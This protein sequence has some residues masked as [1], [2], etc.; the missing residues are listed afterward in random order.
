MV[1]RIFSKDEDEVMP[2]PGEGAALTD[3]EKEILQK[4]ISEG[5]EYERHWAFRSPVKSRLSDLKEGKEKVID[6]FVQERLSRAGFQLQ[7]EATREELIRRVSIDLT[8]LPPS[9]EEV[10]A[11]VADQSQEAYSKVVDRLLSSPRYGERMAAWWLDGARYGDSHGYDN[12]L[13]N[14]QWLSLIHI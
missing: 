9:M 7:E 5:A 10:D 13:E 12:D 11:F 2:P 6:V 14:A 3:A 4:W 8:G 1:H